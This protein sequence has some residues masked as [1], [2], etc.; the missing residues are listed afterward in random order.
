LARF[1]NRFTFFPLVLVL[2]IVHPFVKKFTA[3]A[4]LV[5]LDAMPEPEADLERENSTRYSGFTVV[6]PVE[7]LIGKK[8]GHATLPWGRIS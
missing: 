5:R 7:L 1:N 8:V 4:S 3:G 6:L 2:I